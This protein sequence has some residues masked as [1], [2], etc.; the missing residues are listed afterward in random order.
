MDATIIIPVYNHWED[1][2]LPLLKALRREAGELLVVDDGSEDE[3][4]RIDDD[5]LLTAIVTVARD[6]SRIL[7]KPNGGF[8]SAVN[9][10]A[11]HAT[12]KYL[13]VLNNDCRPEP[14]WLEQLLK[15]LETSGAG[16]VG[17]RML[18]ADPGAYGAHLVGNRATQ[19]AG[20]ACDINGVWSNMPF[21]QSLDRPYEVSAVTGACFA[22]PRELFWRLG[23]LDSAYGTGG[24]DDVDY[25]L[26]ARRAGYL[27]L[28]E[29]RVQVLHREGSTRF[30][31]PDVQQR[32]ARSQE[33]LDERWR[34]GVCSAG[35]GVELLSAAAA[36]A[37]GGTHRASEPAG[38]GPLEPS[39]AVGPLGV[40]PEGGSNGRAGSAAGRVD[41]PGLRTDHGS[42]AAERGGG[43]NGRVGGTVHV[44]WE[45]PSDPT[46]GGSLAVINRALRARL[47]EPAHGV[48][49]GGEKEADL[50]VSHYF[51]GTAAHPVPAGV[52][53]WCVVQPW[54]LGAPPKEWHWT[55]THPAFREL[56]VPSEYC[57]QLYVQ[58]EDVL[59][60]RVHVIPNGVDLGV[61]DPDGP[62]WTHK[63]EVFRFLFVGGPIWRKG[64]DI[65]LE[66]FRQAFRPEEP[67]RLI[68]KLVGSRTFYAGSSLA[69]AG[70][71]QPNVRLLESDDY[72]DT[73]LAALYCSC[74]VVVAPSRA[75]AF[76]LPVLEAMAC[77]KPVIA[78]ALGPTTEFADGIALTPETR[79]KESPYGLHYEVDSVDLARALRYCYEQPDQLAAQAARGRGRALGYGWDSIAKL[80]ADRIRKTVQDG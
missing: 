27:V 77:R 7:H 6:H 59:K 49:L 14:G 28:V 60:D 62:K 70:E 35:A 54:E 22:T 47:S 63:S 71:H 48:V 30:L 67:V 4:S 78:P 38:A 44:A 29:P 20:L 39:G 73:D 41:D 9:F 68:L 58:H 56:W 21:V 57:R 46:V 15:T 16:V 19:S 43:T 64:L 52:R 18:N 13:V 65:L 31:L 45:G 12:G 69:D 10:G 66:A 42:G 5:D 75:E 36:V 25:C 3:T 23:G 37:A 17:A 34:A 53:R 32:I 61:F 11:A 8:A 74:N 1:Q 2:T 26:R 80:Y 76:C 50:V 51:P 55:W 72:S 79:W 40:A 24:C 33:R